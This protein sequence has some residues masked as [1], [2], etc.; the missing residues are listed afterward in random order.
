M[1]VKPG[2]SPHDITSYRPIILLQILSKVLEKILLKRLTPVIDEGKLKPSHEFEFRNEHRTIEQAHRIVYKINNGLESKR[3]SSVAFIDISQ[4]FD[5][6][7][8]TGLL[9]K[10][11]LPFPHPEYTL[12]KSYLTDRTFQIRYQGEYTKLYT[13]QSGVTQG[14]NLGPILFSIFT[15]DLLET[16]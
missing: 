3:C 13:V 16:E 15:A 12:L 8:H 14:S 10:L 2:K 6:I 11:T 4:T 5:K 1:I 7:W 9:Y